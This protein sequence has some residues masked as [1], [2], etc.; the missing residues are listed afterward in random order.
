M[1]PSSPPASAPLRIVGVRT[2]V[3]RAPLAE[4]IQTAFGMMHNRPALLVRVEDE[5]GVFGWGEVWCNLPSVGVE[6]RAHLLDSL[7]AP[8]LRG[9][10]WADPPAAYREL[11]RRLHLLA[12]QSGEPGPIAQV[13]AGA[14]IALWDLTAR[15]AGQPLW[16]LLGGSPT[17][18]V[19]AGALTHTNPEA[20]ASRKLQEGYRAFKLKVG[21]G[22]ERDYANLRALRGLVGP[23]PLMLDANQVWDPETAREMSAVLAE[24]SPLWLEEPMAADLPLALWQ[25]L[26]RDSKIPLAAGENMR[27]AESFDA[28]LA[29]AAFSAIQPD[30]GKW[31]GFTE[32]VAVGRKA[33]AQGVMF[34]PHWLGGGIGLAATLQ[35]KAAVGGPGYVELDANPNPLREIGVIPAFKVREGKITLSDIPGLGVV[36][37]LAAIEPYRVQ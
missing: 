13:I 25:E 26:A 19:C 10:D 4:P 11:S 7:V 18:D 16:R 6:H 30:I 1:S 32:C 17:V 22:K 9:Q 14:D 37:N 20:L 27:G 33:L 31:G 36:P 12:I 8:I 23:L 29:S 24:F 28:A 5:A 3:F 21:F 2:L 34:C 15:R 35:L